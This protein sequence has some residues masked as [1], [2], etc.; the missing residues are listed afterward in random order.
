MTPIST[1]LS[2]A[3]QK[4]DLLSSWF[5][6]MATKLVHAASHMVPPIPRIA[7]IFITHRPVPVILPWTKNARL[8]DGFRPIY[9]TKVA[10]QSPGLV[11]DNK[12]TKE[13]EKEYRTLAQ[14][15]ADLY[16]AV[17]GI[18]LWI[19]SLMYLIFWRYF[20]QWTWWAIWN[21]YWNGL[22]STIIQGINRGIFGVPSAKKSEIHG[23]VE[24]LES[25][26]PTPDPTLNLEKV[27]TFGYI[28]LV[29]MYIKNS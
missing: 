4:Q 17:Q 11:G 25:Q 24:L 22:H 8:G 20:S 2:R 5:G 15:K 9:T 12:E 16:Q 10:E 6:F 27:N 29:E 23:L 14:I 1:L 26:N 3:N 19:F 13:N 28:W 18:S 7:R 21:Q